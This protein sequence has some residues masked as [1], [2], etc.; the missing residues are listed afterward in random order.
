MSPICRWPVPLRAGIASVAMCSLNWAELFAYFFAGKHWA[1]VIHRQMQTAYDSA[2]CF[3]RLT[4]GMAMAD[5]SRVRSIGS[6][7]RR[8]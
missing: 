1:T 4:P 2:A 5:L 8:G 3:L 6:G 7:R